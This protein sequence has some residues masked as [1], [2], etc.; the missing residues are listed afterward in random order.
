MSTP[1]HASGPWSE[2]YPPPGVPLKTGSV[3]VTLDPGQTPGSSTASGVPLA[4]S[5]GGTLEWV[6]PQRPVIHPEV[7]RRLG[8]C[9]DTRQWRGREPAMLP[10]RPLGVRGPFKRGQCFGLGAGKTAR[11]AAGRKRKWGGARTAEAVGGE[12]RGDRGVRGE[13]PFACD[14]PGCDKKF[15]RS[16]ELARHHRTHTGEK[17]FPCPLCSKRF[18]RSDHLTKHARRHP[19]FRP[20]LLRRPGARST[21]PS[22]SLPC[23]L[24]GSPAPSPVPS[25][26]PAGL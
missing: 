21:S 23:S 19:G 26:A 15:A 16:D 25:P 14:W 13:R 1:Q 22:D 3:R 20:E 17:R 5:K 12:A 24:A 6:R 2:L 11:G 9:G 18:T 10:P 8:V 7:G 4:T